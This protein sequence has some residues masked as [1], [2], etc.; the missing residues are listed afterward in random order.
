MIYILLRKIHDDCDQ[1][2]VASENID[3]V[4]K[5]LKSEYK[6][7]KWW[8]L[9]TWN[10]SKLIV[11]FENSNL[12]IKCNFSEDEEVKNEIESQLIMNKIIGEL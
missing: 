4:F 2:E 9:E 11:M 5:R 8:T 6:N 3:D 10:N 7:Y 12:G 1:I